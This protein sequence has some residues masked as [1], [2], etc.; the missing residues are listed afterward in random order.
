[1]LLCWLAASRLAIFRHWWRG[2]YIFLYFFASVAILSWT[3]G[4]SSW[5]TLRQEVPGFY[6]DPSANHRLERRRKLTE[7]VKMREKGMVLSFKAYKLELRFCRQHFPCTN[8]DR[9]DRTLPC[10]RTVQGNIRL[11][12]HLKK[13]TGKLWYRCNLLKRAINLNYT[14]NSNSYRTVNTPR[15]SYKKK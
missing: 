9:Q 11:H 5:S 1:M 6:W 4:S 2:L 13:N 8:V 12:V 15:L 14:L 3:R 7:L 10:V